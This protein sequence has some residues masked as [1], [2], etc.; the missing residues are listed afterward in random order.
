[1][2]FSVIKGKYQSVITYIWRAN[3]ASDGRR[4][5]EDRYFADD[6]YRKHTKRYEIER[7]FVL[8]NKELKLTFGERTSTVIEPEC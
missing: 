8:F 6:L 3:I 2:I 7:V 5:I 4:L 1:M